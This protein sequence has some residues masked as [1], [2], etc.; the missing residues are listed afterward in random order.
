MLT[1]GPLLYAPHPCRQCAGPRSFFREIRVAEYEFPVVGVSF[2]NE[3]GTHRQT[4]LGILYDQWWS[5]DKE[6]EIQVTLRPEPENPYDENAVGV[7]V[8]T[9]DRYAVKAG[10]L[11]REVAVEV[12]EWT[13]EELVESVWVSEMGATKGGGVWLKVGVETSE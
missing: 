5:E 12:L 8:E 3:D 4:I 10:H 7:W 2:E 1:G 11:S 9:P 6:D 13:Q